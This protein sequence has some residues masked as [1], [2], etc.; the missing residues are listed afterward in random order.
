[1]IVQC[2]R[3]DHFT[4]IIQFNAEN[5]T[6]VINLMP[7]LLSSGRKKL[8]ICIHAPGACVP[9]NRVWDIIQE[10]SS[11]VSFFDG[12]LNE[13]SLMTNLIEIGKNSGREVGL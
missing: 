5:E 7:H 10:L 2:F 13:T 1:M 8:N 3:S 12:K 11:L 4:I 9:S 6:H